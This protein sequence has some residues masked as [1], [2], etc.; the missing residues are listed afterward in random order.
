MK[1]QNY[2]ITCLISIKSKNPDS[3]MFH[4]P[5]IN[6]VKL[7]AKAIGVPLIM[8][9]TEGKKEKELEDLEKAIRQAKK[10]HKIEGVVTG[11]LFSQY[12]RE[13]VEKI[14]DR[15][16]LKIFAPLWHMDQE[17]EMKLLVK[18]G[19]EVVMSSI[20]ADGLD[21]GWLGKRIGMREVNRLLKLHDRIG[22]HVAGEG[23]EFES[24]VLDSPDFKKR[25]ELGKIRIIAESEIVARMVVKSAKLSK[26]Q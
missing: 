15:L 16:G 13:R 22:F 1:K 9:E 11:A 26:K 18:E 2:P 5:N 24:L 21:K 17:K 19:F 6:L 10:K 23:G 25:I 3:Y 8:A 14:C 20:A 7:Q 12:Q 4:T